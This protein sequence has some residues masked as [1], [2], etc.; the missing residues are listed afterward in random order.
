MNQNMIKWGDEVK[1]ATNGAV[2]FTVHGQGSLFKNP[3]IKRAVQTGQVEFG[4]Q[5]MQNLGPEKRLF[6]LDGIPFLAPGYD[7]GS[8]SGTRR[9]P[10]RRATCRRRDCAC[11]TRCHGRRRGSS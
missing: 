10:M 9:V 2:Q 1:A 5:L 4:T 11:S 8:S 7:E 6:E 3:E